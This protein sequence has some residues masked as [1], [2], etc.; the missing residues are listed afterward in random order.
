MLPQ[1]QPQDKE[2]LFLTT[3]LLA[4]LFD[5]V[6]FLAFIILSLLIMNLNDCLN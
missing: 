4:V 5:F 3:G 2:L 1:E 6:T